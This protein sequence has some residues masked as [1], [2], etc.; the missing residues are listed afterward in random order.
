MKKIR[1]TESQLVSLIEMIVKESEITELG[2]G[3]FSDIEDLDC[4]KPKG[5]L[6][7]G[8]STVSSESEKFSDSQYLVV[9][10]VDQ[11]T[12]KKVVY[13]YGPQVSENMYN[14]K[15]YQGK[16]IICRIGK[17]LLSEMYDEYEENLEKQGRP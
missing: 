6:R 5:D 11:K 2:Q 3:D 4:V 7:V 14:K 8:I 9:Y 13:G 15:D 12:D 1:L 17:K 16:P 10:Y